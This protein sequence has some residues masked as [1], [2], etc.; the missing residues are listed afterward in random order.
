MLP[1]G[2]NQTQQ[3]TPSAPILCL[4][5]LLRITLELKCRL[6]LHVVWEMVDRR[7]K[8]KSLMRLY[9]KSVKA[10]TASLM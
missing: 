2:W 6:I 4:R 3:F 1:L 7:Q 9:V 5:S 10:L 8:I